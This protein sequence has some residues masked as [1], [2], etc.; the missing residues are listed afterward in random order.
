M[1]IWFE[2]KENHEVRMHF[3]KPMESDGRVISGG[4]QAE[5]FGAQKVADIFVSQAVPLGQIV[6]FEMTTEIKS[7][8]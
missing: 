5:I 3:S 1:K 2:L 6:E 7:T 8:Y 4:H